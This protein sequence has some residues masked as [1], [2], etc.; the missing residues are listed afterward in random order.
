M[1]DDLIR[2]IYPACTPFHLADSIR[3][4]QGEETKSDN[5]ECQQTKKQTSI[6]CDFQLVSGAAVCGVKG[7][8]SADERRTLQFCLIAA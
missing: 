4:G 6:G 1:C 8:A 3:K 2:T 7:R 5:W